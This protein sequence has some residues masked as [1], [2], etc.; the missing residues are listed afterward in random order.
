MNEM[1]VY[2]K[3]SA[4]MPR[5]SDP[6]FYWLTRDGPYLCRNHPFFETDVPAARGPRAKPLADAR[7]AEA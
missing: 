1:P 6:E 2:L 3:T 5:P 7:P 4:D